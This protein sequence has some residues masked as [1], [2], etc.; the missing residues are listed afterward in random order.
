[1]T[2]AIA[3]NVGPSRIDIAYERLGEPSAPPV[4]LVMGLGAQLIAWPDG[5]CDELVRRG[6][7]L[8]RFDNRD[9]G[10]STHFTG[11]PD[12]AAALAGDYASAA[13]TLSDMAADAV[14]LLDALAIDSAHVVGA[15]MGGAIAQTIAIESPRRVRSL[16]SMMSTTGD[17]AVGQPH[18]VTRSV[19]T[20]APATT[21]E[22]VVQRF[23]DASRVLGSPGFPRDEAAV[24]LR[25]GREFDR[26]FDPGAMVRQAVA[27]LA[28]GDR[29]Q[30]LAGVHV[31]ALVIHGAADPMC[32]VGGGRAVAAAIPGAELLV[33]DGMGHDL[34]RAVWPELA[35]R[36]AEIVARGE[37]VMLRA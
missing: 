3:S 2:I 17:R 34:P 24:A 15:S 18:A 6:V 29:T 35:T 21:R 32:D 27:T 25:A 30:Q 37:A 14:G 7:Q 20:G 10:E 11:A 4:V 12:F 31:P 1:M 13:Y 36:I 22:S 23:V 19:F 8:V 28:S 26:A 9:A 16:V 5:F 33:I